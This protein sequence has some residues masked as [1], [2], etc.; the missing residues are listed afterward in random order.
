MKNKYKLIDNLVYIIVAIFFLVS[1]LCK[2][3]FDKNIFVYLTSF[4][5]GLSSYI[6]FI[7]DK[8]FLS[9]NK[10][11]CI[12]LFLFAFLAPVDQYNA[13]T[14]FWGLQKFGDDDYLLANILIIL[15]MVLYFFIQKT[16][17]LKKDLFRDVIII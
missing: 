4:L 2:I 16:D 6:L 14:S 17:I 3:D 5:I 9:I 1:F 13:G 8:S 11:I 7:R 10:I 12:Y 15:F